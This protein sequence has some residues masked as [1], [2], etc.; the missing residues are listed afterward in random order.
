[1]SL[2]SCAANSILSTCIPT[3]GNDRQPPRPGS[4]SCW[5]SWAKRPATW[6]RWPRDASGII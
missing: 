2:V 1:M 4:T 3:T 5:R 6:S